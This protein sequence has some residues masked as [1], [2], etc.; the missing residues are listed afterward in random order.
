[1]WETD[2]T[3]IPLFRGLMYMVAIIDVYSRRVM[4]WSILNTMNVEWCKEVYQ[5]AIGMHDKPEILNS[6]QRSH[7]TSPVFTQ[8]SIDKQ[9]KISMDGKGKASDNIYIERFWRSIEYEYDYLGDYIQFYTIIILTKEES[10][11]SL[12]ASFHYVTFR[13]TES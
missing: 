7:F 12:D 2:I 10:H 9:I 8:F 1:M 6:D 11:D 4:S 5:D 13:M 3:Y